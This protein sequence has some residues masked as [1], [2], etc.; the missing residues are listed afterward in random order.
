TAA[1]P[2]QHLSASLVNNLTN[3][4]PAPSQF[5][6]TTNNTPRRPSCRPQHKTLF[7]LVATLQAHGA[8]PLSGKHYGSA[9]LCISSDK[10]ATA[11][12][13]DT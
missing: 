3:N 8:I 1:R 2:G 13:T 7:C 10:R 9:N 12:T 5:P 11:L 6:Y 4:C